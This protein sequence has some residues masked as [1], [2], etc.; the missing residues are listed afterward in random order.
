MRTEA[1]R[2][3]K[4]KTYSGENSQGQQYCNIRDG[5]QVS[6]ELKW[7]YKD[8]R[9]LRSIHLLIKRAHIISL[10]LLVWFR[11]QW[12]GSIW[13]IMSHETIN[14]EF[15]THG[16]RQ[17]IGNGWGSVDQRKA[18]AWIV[19]PFTFKTPWYFLF[20]SLNLFQS[21]ILFVVN[22]SAKLT[23]QNTA[24]RCNN[25]LHWMQQ[26]FNEIIQFLTSKG[27]D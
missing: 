21:F 7:W 22:K 18:K 12:P 4:G 6:P 23:G 9:A 26:S 3:N 2:E 25:G 13:Q 20:F 27:K 1:V 14:S 10:I 11:F 15:R 24:W 5:K 16:V 17:M 19:L 8:V